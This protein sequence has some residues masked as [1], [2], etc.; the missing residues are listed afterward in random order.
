MRS[1]AKAP[2]AGSTRIAAAS[3]FLISLALLGLIAASARATVEGVTAEGAFPVEKDKATLNGY[4][5]GEG[6]AAGY[7]FEW[8]ETESYGN[9]TPEAPAGTE[10]GYNPVAPVQITGLKA[11]STYHYRLV[12]KDPDGTVQSSD[13]PFTTAPAVSNLSTDPISALTNQSAELNASFDGDGRE[14]HYYFEWGPT[15]AYG[16][17][18]PVPPGSA[19]QAPEGERIAVPPIA[20]SGLQQG[21]TYHYR[22]IASNSMGITEGPDAS[23]KTAEPPLVADVRTREVLAGSAQLIGSVNPN[24]GQTTYRF[25]WG[26]SNSYGNSVPVPDAAVGNGGSKEPVSA[27]VEG[28]TAG[29]TYHFRLVATNP[30]GTTASPDQTFGFYPAICPNSQLR[31]ETG[32]NSLPDCRAYELVT[33]G[34]GNGATIMPQNGP[35]SGFAT[36]PAKLSFGKGFSAFPS[37]PQYGEPPNNVGDLYIATR[38]D[39]GWYQRYIGLTGKETT[40]MAGPPTNFIS[41]PF[42]G[43]STTHNQ[44]GVQVSPQ[45]DRAIDYVGGWGAIYPE[46]RLYGDPSN[47]P[48]VWDTA[49]G[50]LLERWPTN[51]GQV[52]GGAGFIGVPQASANFSHFVF[53]SNVVFSDDGK[54]E[55]STQSFKFGDQG[56]PPARP[57]ASIYDNDLKTGTVKLASLKEDNQTQFQGFVYNLSED[58][59]HILMGEQETSFRLTEPVAPVSLTGP[60]YLRVNGVHTYEIAAG[61]PIRYVGSTADGE[62]VYLTSPDQLTPDDTDTSN[63]LFVWRQSDPDSLTRISVGAGGAGGNSDSCAPESAW[64]TGCG[65]ESVEFYPFVDSKGNDGGINGVSDQSIAGKSGDI[66]FESPEQLDGAKGEVG[67]VNLYLYR[68]GTVRFVATMDPSVYCTPPTTAGELTEPEAPI[69]LPARCLNASVARMQVTADGEHMAFMTKSNVTS[70]DSGGKIEMYTYEPNSGRVT[71]VSCRPDGQA[72]LGDTLGSQN[73]LFLANDGRVFFFTP[74]PLVPRDT[75]EVGDVYEYTEGKAQLISA[76]L[77][78]ETSE[79]AGIQGSQAKSGLVG[80]SA[81]GI[82]VYFATTDTLVTQDHNGGAL[83]IYDARTGGGFPADQPVTRCPSA[84]E[85]H[86]PGASAPSMPADRTSANLGAPRKAKAHKAKKHKKTKKHKKKRAS[87]AKRGASKA[88]QGG[89]NRG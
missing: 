50:N 58:G 48:Y 13:T 49:S 41:N 14:T 74:D 23:F 16:N 85:C 76:G 72:P 77:G 69:L 59:S 42:Q 46:K 35:N 28:L 2:F 65:V 56:N 70:Y 27:K 43:A 83:K 45:M 29:L 32:A 8:G 55:A 67:R 31:Q 9:T 47:A 15:T 80:I 79:L 38:T 73:G 30:Y 64:T 51:L 82:D 66:Y 40:E 84:D 53:S 87:R 52:P 18:T 86:G 21:A 10:P 12:V 19:V 88:K 63:D 89:K 7:Y 71:C 20:I 4:F 22:V 78:E 24:L 11:N 25:E 68:K 39:S 75:D 5:F 44:L 62:T 36:N 1:H 81:N 3:A 6:K 37:E 60:L 61:H 26:P 57:K 33:P 54:G 34:F 17:T